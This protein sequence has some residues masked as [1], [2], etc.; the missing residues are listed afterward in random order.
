MYTGTLR[1]RLQRTT[2]SI[3]HMQL[4]VI[5]AIKNCISTMLLCLLFKA[6]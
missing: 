3:D 2:V 4:V 1:H 6:L 5:V